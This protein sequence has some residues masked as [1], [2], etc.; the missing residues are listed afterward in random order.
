MDE[1][2]VF[3]R[4]HE[5]LDDIEPRAGTYERFRAT[6]TNP[7][8]AA[9]RRPVFRMRLSKMGFR[10]AAALAAVAILSALV[11]GILVTHHTPPKS[12][13]PAGPDKNT[14][15]YRA[16]MIQDYAGMNQSTSA[17][18]QTITDT[19]CAAAIAPVN[20]ALQK[21]ISD[22]QSF[23][24]PVAYMTLDGMIRKHLQTVID[25]Q[26]AAIGR[27]KARD[28]A[29]FT[30]AMNAA[31]YERAWIDP[32]AFETEGHYA[33]VATSYR[34]A[35]LMADHSLQGC[36]SQSPGPADRPCSTLLYGSTCVTA[37]AS[38]CEAYIETTLTELE[39]FVIAD[40][41]NPA[42]AKFSKQDTAY[43]S[44]L[45]KTDTDLLS[46]SVAMATLNTAAL[47]AAQSSFTNDIQFTQG[48]VAD[49]VAG[50]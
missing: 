47:D 29:G 39:T 36:I 6:F 40:L 44:D 23:R 25:V 35:R 1:R 4:F 27:Q 11:A 8:A 3:E 24:T 28:V 9:K 10:V 34:D 50:A 14:L 18:C 26:N 21:W 19:G 31:F 30:L 17:H 48:A 33:P 46:M 2:A 16:L 5:A 15:A 32:A 43:Q 42:P 13:I 38:T 22:L 49:L 45:A 20:A 7:P 12:S 41:Q 37:I